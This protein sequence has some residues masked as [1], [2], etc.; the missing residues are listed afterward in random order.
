MQQGSCHCDN[1]KQNNVDSAQNLSIKILESKTEQLEQNLPTQDKIDEF[2]QVLS[3][4]YVNKSD[5]TQ[6]ITEVKNTVIEMQQKEEDFQ[7]LPEK[8]DSLVRELES[9]YGGGQPAPGI[10]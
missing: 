5:F 8:V 10:K 1:D 9:L 6:E 3:D 4:T 7:D 2:Q